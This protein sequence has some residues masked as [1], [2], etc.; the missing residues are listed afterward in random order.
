MRSPKFAGTLP[1]GVSRRS[2]RSAF[3]IFELMVTITIISLLAAAA[4]PAVINSKRRA[5]ASV[6][7]NDMRVF[8]TAFDTY[9]HE[10]GGWPA[11]VDAGVVPPEM[12]TRINTTAWLR[13]GVFGGHYNW[14]NNQVHYG[15]TYRAV[16]A[17]SSTS[18]SAVAQDA[19]L[20]EA[21]DRAI[22]DGN[23]TT[24]SFRLGADDEPIFIVAQ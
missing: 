18:D 11:E 6:I 21:I 14:D 19:D 13:P 5:L 16:I 22:D 9:A 10:V 20:Y 7:G 3:T 4:V 24:G 23:L 2:R 1:G 15:V 17:I 12:A 8:A